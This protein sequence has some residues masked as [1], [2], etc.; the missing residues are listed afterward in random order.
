MDWSIEGR[1]V[2]ITGGNAGIGRATAI[3][4]ARAGARVTITTRSEESGR[5][6][7]AAIG[8]ESGREIDRV[9]LDLA[10]L[11]SVAR[12]AAA[13]VSRN[14]RLDV[15]IN[16]AGG[17][18]GRRDVTVNGFE[19]TWGVNY[20]GPFSLTRNLLDILQAS[21]PARIVNVGSSAHGY[22]KEGIRFDDPEFA[23]QRYRMMKA[24]GHSKL[25]NILHARALELRYGD[26]G[27]HAFS[28]HPGLVR[29]SIGRGDSLLVSAAV[30]LAGRRMRTPSEGA[31]TVVWLA[32]APSLPH[33]LGG[34]FEDRAEARSTEAA[35]NDELANHLWSMTEEILEAHNARA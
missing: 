19:R 13:Y 33:P 30:R 7:V 32:T 20:L 34:Y 23:D 16:N 5:E 28:M 24:Y 22:A 21:A 14:H 27:V 2:L 15:L 25:A 3:A 9:S 31:D 17:M 29:T 26:V 11:A 6:A 35:R 4:L 18:F 8:A 1:R 10:D 12:A